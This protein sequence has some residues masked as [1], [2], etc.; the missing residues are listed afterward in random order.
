MTTID[1][2]TPIPAISCSGFIQEND[3]VFVE[4]PAG[5]YLVGDVIETISG[6]GRTGVLVDRQNV[7]KIFKVNESQGCSHY[8][9]IETGETISF[10][11][12]LKRKQELDT[13]EVLTDEDGEQYTWPSI[14]ERHAFELFTATWHPMYI[15]R[16]VRQ[17]VTVNIVGEVPKVDNQFIV[18]LRKIGGNLNNTL[19]EYNQLGHIMSVITSTLHKHGW[20]PLTEKPPIGGRPKGALKQYWLEPGLEYSRLFMSDGN[21]HYLTSKIPGLKK[22]EKKRARTGTFEECEAAYKLNESEVSDIMNA[23]IASDVPITQ[24]NVATIGKLCSDLNT[25]QQTLYKVESM[26]KTHD[27]YRSAMRLIESI[28]KEFMK[29]INV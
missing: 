26:K 2:T 22:Y 1:Q 21:D 28:Q 23:F 13:R 12:F 10:T 19:Y 16:T 6:Y 4:L 9:N 7:D 17:P 29:A 3:L 27:E 5:K 20:T 24:L 25:L 14:R 15:I 8:Q 11:N 18:P